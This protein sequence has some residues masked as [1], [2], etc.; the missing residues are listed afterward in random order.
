MVHRSVWP[1]NTP[2]QGAETPGNRRD[3]ENLQRNREFTGEMPDPNEIP[4]SLTPCF[5]SLFF[6]S[7]FFF[8]FWWL[9]FYPSFISFILYQNNS[10]TTNLHIFAISCPFSYHPHIHTSYTIQSK[11][12]PYLYHD[13]DRL[14]KLCDYC[15]ILWYILMRYLRCCI[16]GCGDMGAWWKS[17]CH[18]FS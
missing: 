3:L 15:P 7:L 18:D 4:R 16:L 12:T 1:P 6:S 14:V 10:T 17:M 8:L 13:W 5:F 9:L 2:P 11:K